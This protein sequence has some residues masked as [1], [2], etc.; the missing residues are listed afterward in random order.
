M[1]HFLCKQTSERIGKRQWNNQGNVL[2]LKLLLEFLKGSWKLDNDF[3]VISSSDVLCIDQ[4]HCFAERE[5]SGFK[6]HRN[7]HLFLS[8][9][10][11]LYF[12]SKGVVLIRGLNFDAV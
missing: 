12:F 8:V 11:M 5:E 2:Y 7:Q 6:K 1:D 9:L 4:T 3:Q 10:T